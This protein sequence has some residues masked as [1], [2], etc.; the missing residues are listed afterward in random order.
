MTNMLK[1]FYLPIIPFYNKSVLPTIICSLPYLRHILLTEKVDLVHGHSAF[2]SLAHEA[3]MVGTLLNLPTVF[4]DHSL[5]GFSDASAI[6]T[7]T[8]LKYSLV[9]T[10]HT[11]CVS[12]TG[13]ENTV[14]RSEVAAEN[15]SVI[16]NAVDSVKF[17]PPEVAKR[18]SR[19][20][21]VVLGSRLVYR[22]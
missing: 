5:F 15:V 3:L 18:K 9:N 16:P 19:V 4:T 20:V 10:S 1:V 12:H 8:F 21:T 2:S 13:K 14:L 11:I 17:R 6:V 7:N 22:K